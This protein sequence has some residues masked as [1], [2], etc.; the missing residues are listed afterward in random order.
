MTRLR[1][2]EKK[3]RALA[4]ARLAGMGYA[5]W[6]APHVRFKKE[7]DIFGFADLL[8]VKGRSV[9]FVQITTAKNVSA[10]VSKCR[11]AMHGKGITATCEVWGLKPDLSWRIVSV[12]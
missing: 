11:D 9:L 4:E 8:A 5:T 2:P 1:L 7:Q 3:I 10:R 12:S 6:A